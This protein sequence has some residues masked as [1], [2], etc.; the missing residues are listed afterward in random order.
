MTYLENTKADL[1]SWE[2][3]KKYLQEN[4]CNEGSMEINMGNHE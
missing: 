2:F 4:L 1:I 3:Y